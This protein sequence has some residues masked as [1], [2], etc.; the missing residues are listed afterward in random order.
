MS[1]SELKRIQVCHPPL[2]SILLSSFSWP[3]GYI[4]IYMYV[5]MYR[6]HIHMSRSVSHRV[7]PMRP[8]QICKRKL[9]PPPSAG[10]GKSG[11]RVLA[12]ARLQHRRPIRYCSL[13]KNIA[14]GISMALA[15]R[16]SMLESL[17]PRSQPSAS[18]AA[19]GAAFF[20]FLRRYLAPPWD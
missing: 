4:Y 18:R 14:E 9:L 1:S 12:P 15:V 7:H 20:I 16:D 19:G 13:N 11:P 3:Y 8:T 6:I 5:Y 10:T 2:P 17:I